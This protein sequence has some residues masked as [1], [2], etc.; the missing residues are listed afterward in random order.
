MFILNAR[1]YYEMKENF[2]NNVKCPHEKC[3]CGQ[4]LWVNFRTPSPCVGNYDK[5]ECS[6]YEENI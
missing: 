6:N 3:I 4:R 5:K 1:D 2:K